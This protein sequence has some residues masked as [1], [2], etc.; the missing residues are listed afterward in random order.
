MIIELKAAS[1][2]TGDT[3]LLR[4]IDWVVRAGEHWAVLGLNGSGKTSLLNLLNGYVP[5]SSGVMRVLGRRYGA[6]DWRALRKRVG[7][8]SS[9]LQERFYG[10][11]TA[12][13][14]VLSGIFS[15]IGLYDSPRRKDIAMARSI[16]E[17]L[18]CGP[19][20]GHNYSSLS[21]GEKQKVLI[22]RALVSRPRLLIMDEPST[23]LDFFSREE[24]LAGVHGFAESNSSAKSPLTLIYVTHH[25]EEIL[26]V[27]THVLL[28]KGGQIHS[29][30]E[31]RKILTAGNLSSFFGVPVAL[32]WRSG[33][34]WLEMKY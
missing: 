2:I 13:E 32:R 24:F 33:R 21:Q 30:G 12:L 19:L 3:E 14:I 17:R 16:L 1:S 4:G 9:S 8:I 15:T 23:G 28:L 7:F 26:P 22:A 6:Y 18:K 10:G 20:A 11:E 34:A 31:T 25:L 29:A 27:F 5:L